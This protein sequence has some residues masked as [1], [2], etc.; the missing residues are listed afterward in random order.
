MPDKTEL[1]VVSQQIPQ[2][3]YDI[4][5]RI[6]RGAFLIGGALALGDLSI[7]ICTFKKYILHGSIIGQTIGL[8]VLVGTAFIVGFLLSSLSSALDRIW[9]YLSPF[10][11]EEFT[12]ATGV[13]LRAEC[14]V[15]EDSDPSFDSIQQSRDIRRA[16]NALLHILWT[17]PAA[18][19]IAQL[20]SKRDAEKMAAGSLA[21]ASL[22]LI[23]LHR[24]SPWGVLLFLMAIIILSLIAYDHFRKRC[25]ETPLD[26]IADVR[27]RFD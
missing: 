18:L 17:Y 26:V 12:G 20:T 5:G 15:I 24:H 27:R 4:I 14:G 9:D 3:W 10:K 11:L 21:I 23:V 6:I 7:L 1:D 8:L 19:P 13:I 22:T 2:V 25:L 16:R